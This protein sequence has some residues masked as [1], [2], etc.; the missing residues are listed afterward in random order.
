MRPATELAVA[1]GLRLGAADAIAVDEQMRTNIEDVWAAGDCVHTHHRLLG[2][3]HLGGPPPS[4][5]L[6][7]FT[8]GKLG[9]GSPLATG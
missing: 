6:Y 1:A 8:W 7:E 3:G 4:C 9:T 2:G 5:S